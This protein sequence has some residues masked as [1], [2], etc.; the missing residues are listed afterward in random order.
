MTVSE[1][2]FEDDGEGHFHIDGR[3][4]SREEFYK[5]IGVKPITGPCYLNGVRVTPEEFMD[6][7]GD[8][9]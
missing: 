8:T 5:A 1:F 2:K 9:N 4:V 6:F 7:M 3:E